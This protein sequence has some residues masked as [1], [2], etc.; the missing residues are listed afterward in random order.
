MTYQNLSP[1]DPAL[2]LYRLYPKHVAK[3][4]A[5]K[6][7]KKA[8]L[9]VTFE[10]LK[11]GVLRYKNSKEVQDLI[12][13]GE[14]RFIMHAATW[15]NGG[16]WED[17]IPETATDRREAKRAEMESCFARV[18]KM[19][20]YVVEAAIEQLVI[21]NPHLRGMVRYEDT[22]RDDDD[23][24]RRCVSVCKIIDAVGDQR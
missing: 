12:A 11:A 24:K 5:L 16:R 15:F 20:R 2:V 9:T 13:S 18:Q 19:K 21:R 23:G 8:L 7:I 1:D 22:T 4:A 6:A 10:T 14:Q 17:E 3:I